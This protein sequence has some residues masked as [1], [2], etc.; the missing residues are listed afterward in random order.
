MGTVRVRASTSPP[1]TLHALHHRFV[2][3]PTLVGADF[4]HSPGQPRRVY[5]HWQLP[6]GPGDGFTVQLMAGGEPVAQ[7][8][9]PSLPD[10]G[11]LTS[12]HDVPA[13]SLAVAV[14]PAGGEGHMGHRVPWGILSSK[15]VRLPEPSTGSR[16]VPLGGEMAL[17]RV[18]TRRGIRLSAEERPLLGIP[19]GAGEILQ[20]DVHWLSLGA[21][22][23]DRVV[24]V[25]A[26]AWGVTHDSVPALGAIPTLKWIRG[27]TVRDRHFLLLP[28][29]ASGE[30]HLD[31][32]VYDHFTH[33]PL[34]LLDDRLAKLGNM[35]ALGT[36]TH[37]Q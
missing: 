4:D 24:S 6:A 8:T 3:G 15:P 32:I 34:A 7:A 12:A 5:L 33:Q 27:T 35:T 18:E 21:L 14:R 2:D 10:G 1:A 30:A 17:T 22:T 31:L 25:Q 11:Y 9:L 23:R 20:I 29:E 13:A 16:F 37:E 36:V 19:D 28:Q 26:L